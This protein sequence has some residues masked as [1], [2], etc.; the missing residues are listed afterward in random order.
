VRLDSA[1]VFLIRVVSIPRILLAWS[2]S[3]SRRGEDMLRD[4]RRRDKS[5]VL[6]SLVSCALSMES[7]IGVATR[8]VALSISLFC[9][10]LARVRYAF[11]G[12]LS[13]RRYDMYRDPRSR[14]CGV[15]VFGFPGLRNAFWCLESASRRWTLRRSASVCRRRVL[16][17]PLAEVHFLES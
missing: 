1:L 4:A 13:R 8:G 14:F 10:P 17:L 5:F 3:V 9:L 16:W 7:S 11:C 15:M 6:A 2:G 12:I